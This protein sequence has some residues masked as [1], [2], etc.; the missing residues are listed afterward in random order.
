MK[1]EDWKGGA[2]TTT[3]LHYWSEGRYCYRRESDG[4]VQWEYPATTHTDM[5][6][7]TTPPH[8]GIETK[9][10]VQPA[11][12][13]CVSAAAPPSPPAFPSGAWRARTPPPPAWADPPPPGCDDLPP[14]LPPSQEDIGDALASFYSD[15]AELEKVE[16]IPSAPQTRSA[17]PETVQQKERH[18]ESN[19]ERE[20]DKDTKVSKKKTKVKISASV[21]LKH[22]SV[23][24]MVAKWQQVAEEI[25][26][27]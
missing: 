12:A 24:S 11:V 4:F 23:S 20:R 9:D 16:K 15:I 1:S 8:P 6:I 2:W 7:C 21:G 3:Q 17:S 25:N 19:R 18:K 14:P 26:S 22:K 10:E 5:D 13:A 27:D